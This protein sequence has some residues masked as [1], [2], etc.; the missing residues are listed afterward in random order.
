M[1]KIASWISGSEDLYP[2]VTGCGSTLHLPLLREIIADRPCL[3]SS[4]TNTA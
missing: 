2:V 3:F 1:L 4:S